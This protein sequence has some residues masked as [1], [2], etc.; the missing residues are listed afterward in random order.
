MMIKLILHK[1]STYITFSYV[2]ANPL[3]GVVL[4][5]WLAGLQKKVFSAI[6]FFY[7]FKGKFYAKM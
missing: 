2:M 3:I 4:F 7:F 1:K 5:N 6:F